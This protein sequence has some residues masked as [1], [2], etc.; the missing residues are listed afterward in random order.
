MIYTRR[1]RLMTLHFSH[2]TFTDARTFI[3]VSSF[4]VYSRSRVPL[5]PPFPFLSV[6]VRDPPARRIIG[7]EFHFHPVTGQNPDEVN[8]HLPGDM[9]QH[10]VTAGQ[11]DPEHRIGQHLHNRPFNLDRVL[12]R[13]PSPRPC[14]TRSARAHGGADGN[15]LRNN[16]PPQTRRRSLRGN[17]Q[18]YTAEALPRPPAARPSLGPAR[19]GVRCR[20][21]GWPAGP[22][23]HLPG[24]RPRG[25]RAPG[26]GP[27]SPPP[28]TR[29][30]PFP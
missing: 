3:P 4:P 25:R 21:P 6:S 19:L 15:V 16:S 8:P 28:S 29:P 1:P 17:L 26:V 12:L 20:P 22:S 14:T 23:L 13:H 11:L 27:P 2:L 18:D 10:P 9:R 24:R 7:R 30:P 5:F